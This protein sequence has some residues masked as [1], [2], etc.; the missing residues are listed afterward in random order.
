MLERLRFRYRIA[1]LVGL[2]AFGLVTVT[3]VALVYLRASERQLSGIETRYV[4]LLEVN[5]DLAEAFTR[6]ARAFEDA[7]AAA[8]EALLDE[9]KEIYVQL[10]ARTHEDAAVIAANGTEPER[11]EAALLRY[12]ETAHS[13]T[14]RL[15]H[16]VPAE[17]LTAA[18][19]TMRENWRE[20]SDLLVRATHPDRKK[21]AAAFENTR[22]AQRQALWIDFSVAACVLLLMGFVSWRLI[23]RTV[24]SLREVSQGVERFARGDFGE[25]ITVEANDEIGD[26]AREANRTAARLREYRGRT[27][28]LLLETKQQA[29]EIARASNYKSAFLANM[30][31]ELRT[32]LNSIMILSNVLRENVDGTLT[33]KH[34]EFATLI[35]KCGQEL[36][37]LISEVLD[38]AK[39]E[40]GK[41]SM[42]YAPL[43]LAKLEDYVRR[44]FTPTAEAKGLVFTVE[45]AA[46]LPEE[47]VT[48]EARVIQIVK[49]LLSN[50]FKFTERGSVHLRIA[51]SHQR[52]GM[53]ALEVTDSGIGIAEDKHAWVFEAFAQADSGTSRRYGGTGLGLAIARQL[54]I[55][56]GGD[57]VLDSVVG[58]GST[59]TLFLPLAGP[60]RDEAAVAAPRPS[61][62][63]AT[64]PP[65]LDIPS[66]ADK[67]VLLVDDDMRNLYSLSNMLTTRSMHV[68]TA[69]DGLEAL[70][71]LAR[72][73]AIDIVLMDVRMPHLDG[74]EA[75]RQIRAQ[76]RFAKLP[77]ITL[78]AS[79][80][81]GERERCLEAGASEFLLKPVDVNQLV[82]VLATLLTRAGS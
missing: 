54:A 34:V 56:L 73:P 18:I 2:A 14:L 36:L 77:I 60:P 26:L 28:A 45:A 71:A 52:A 9:A 51:R 8:D 33:A 23:R 10:A 29:D 16:G 24:R 11:L 1:L 40:A 78:T 13:V 49:N 21:L 25:E 61:R 22:R 7:A 53:L 4:P 5:R 15:V 47:V 74:V 80:L 58:V 69:T 35:N 27:E 68:V 65:P 6:L 43:A 63:L 12:Y 42:D 75:I 55:R 64:V 62:P 76:P 82:D 67:T 41:Q 79:V 57:L 37:G 44:L 32:P 20:Y 72:T 38:L 19:D 39:V 66:L 70:D 81:P 3:T 46:D 50:A 48:D 30:S 59:F 31:H 17:Q